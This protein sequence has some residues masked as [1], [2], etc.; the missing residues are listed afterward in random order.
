MK[1]VILFILIAL[2]WSMC[3]C[4]NTQ[5]PNVSDISSDTIPFRDLQQEEALSSEQL[6]ALIERT[7]RL[8]NYKLLYNYSSNVDSTMILVMHD[9]KNT[10]VQQVVKNKIDENGVLSMKSMDEYKYVFSEHTKY[11]KVNDE[12]IAENCVFT[13]PAQEMTYMYMVNDLV[14]NNFFE[15][16]I[17]TLDA[18]K[19]NIV[20]NH[21]TIPDINLTHNDETLLFEDVFLTFEGGYLRE[22]FCTNSTQSICIQLTGVDN[23][24]E[25][26][27]ATNEE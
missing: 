6:K 20:K 17:N 1:Q 13:T 11:T 10:Q 3:S 8:S 25:E 12:W 2:C 9:G 15:T 14:C 23:V 19:Y 4:N 24:H 16:L 27:A 26:S 21:Y 5:E 22:I 7:G 18:A